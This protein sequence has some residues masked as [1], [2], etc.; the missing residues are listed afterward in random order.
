[1][2]HKGMRTLFV[3]FLLSIVPVRMAEA[4]QQTITDVLS[5]LMTN[6]S[7]A[8]D[9]FVRDEQA[10]LATSNTIANLFVLDLA[11]LPS[12][13]AAGFTYRIDPAL[14]T[15]IRTSESFGP[16]FTQRSL[17]AGQNHASFGVSYRS[18]NFTNIDGRS[19]RDGTLLSTA[20]ILR[21]DTT[22]FDIETVS[23][24]I[25][26]DTMTISGSYAITD[27][28]DIS[29]GI[30][31]VHLSLQGERVDTYRG[32]RLVQ[33]RGTASASGFGDVVVRSRYNVM[34]EG[35]SGVAVGAEVRLPTGSEENLLGA[36]QFA[37]TP[38]I[39]GSVER[40][41]VGVHGDLGYSFDKVSNALA[42]SA[43]VT[44]AAAPRVTVI[45]ELLGRR[46]EALGRLVETIQPH[47]RLSGV[48]TIRLT[49]S[50]E[51]TN[52][53]VAVAGF[54]WNV[55]STWLMTASVLRSITSVGLNADYVP[56]I[57]FDGWFGK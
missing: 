50:G 48:D 22:P 33:A 55:A 56:S 51:T 14:G 46:L 49:S 3:V 52:R 30:P 26:T 23:L 1:M 8:T 37:F 20:S 17:L 21:G 10:A 12:S 6:R 18:T 31:F 54:K 4:Q 39:I 13:S 24:R 32:R 19:L 2:E 27:Q 45:G 35:A 28:L 15:P 42:Y 44:V 43:A 34:Q 29:A 41:R 36:G 16:I 7:I 25:R 40:D 11:S 38:R 5:F 53:L 57:T 9:D 47:P